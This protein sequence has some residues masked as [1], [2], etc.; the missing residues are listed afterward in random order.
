ML[1]VSPALAAEEHS[2]G[3]SNEDDDSDDLMIMGQRWFGLTSYN[4]PNA[5]S[6]LVMTEEPLLLEI[7]TGYVPVG[8]TPACPYYHSPREAADNA[9]VG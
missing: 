8:S 6:V 5:E 1:P 9:A 3:T 2:P 4:T 7:A